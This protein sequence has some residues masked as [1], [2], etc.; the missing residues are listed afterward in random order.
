MDNQI[1]VELECFLR[2]DGTVPD[3]V[4]SNNY[5]FLKAERMIRVVKNNVI[6]IWAGAKSDFAM[7]CWERTLEGAKITLNLTRKC[8]SPGIS[9]YQCLNG[10]F[11]YSRNSLAPL[12]SLVLN[13]NDCDVR[14]TWDAHRVTG[15]YV[16]TSMQHYRVFQVVVSS[17]SRTHVSDTVSGTLLL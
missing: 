17:T 4:P 7:K 3:Y 5:Q 8:V 14:A 13:Y 16:D 12:G 9:A 15:F 11:N 2:L 10:K 1:S 6:S